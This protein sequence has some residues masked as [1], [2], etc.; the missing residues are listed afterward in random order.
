[1]ELAKYLYDFSFFDNCVSNRTQ[2]LCMI[3]DNWSKV[4][5]MTQNIFAQ[6]A[7]EGLIGLDESIERRCS[8]VPSCN[9]ACVAL[10]VYC[11]YPFGHLSLYLVT[12]LFIIPR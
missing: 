9:M 4:K 8:H 11:V 6:S 5:S 1:M 3:Y 10:I 12:N 2:V 7:A